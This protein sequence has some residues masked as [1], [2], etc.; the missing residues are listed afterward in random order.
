MKPFIK[1][2]LVLSALLLWG[3]ITPS[4]PSGVNVANMITLETVGYC[5]DIDF[6]DSLLV[7][8][9]L[10]VMARL[11]MMKFMAPT[12]K[13]TKERNSRVAGFALPAGITIF[14]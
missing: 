3:C 8:S 6:N 7:A 9:I 4:E 13:I 12:R 5:R 1:D 10:E 11:L 2:A 14:C